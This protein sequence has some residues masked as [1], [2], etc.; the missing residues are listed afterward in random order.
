V[1][2]DHRE[3]IFPEKYA[4]RHLL[5]PVREECNPSATTKPIV[6][7]YPEEDSTF[8]GN[9]STEVLEKEE[10]GVEKER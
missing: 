1:L 5:W 3:S 10:R 8:L 9:G 7:T 4:A 6:E 2:G